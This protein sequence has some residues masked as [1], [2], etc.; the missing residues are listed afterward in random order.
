MMLLWTDGMYK[1]E[2]S[3]YVIRV[4]TLNSKLNSPIKQYDDSRN[5]HGRFP[6]L[7]L[8]RSPHGMAN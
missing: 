6:D 4:F 5:L 3:L 2:A 7:T 1:Y 8:K